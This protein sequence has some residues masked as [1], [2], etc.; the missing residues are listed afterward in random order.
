MGNHVPTLSD[1]PSGVPDTDFA[2]AVDDALTLAVPKTSVPLYAQTIGWEFVPSGES[3]VDLGGF[4]VNAAFGFGSLWAAVTNPPQVVRIDPTTGTIIATISAGS[5]PANLLNGICCSDDAVWFTDFTAGRVGR[6]D[7]LTNTASFPAALSGFSTPLRGIVFDGT[8]IW[9]VISLALSDGP[10]QVKK[11]DPSTNTVVATVTVGNEVYYPC[12]DGADHLWVPNFSDNTVSR[13][14]IT[15]HTVTST[16]VTLANPQWAFCNGPHVFVGEYGNDSV[17][18]YSVGSVSNSAR[19]SVAAGAFVH[20]ILVVDD[21]LWVVE[22]G[23]NQIQV[24]NIHSGAVMKTIPVGVDPA[25]IVFDGRD[26]WNVDAIGETLR[27][28]P[29]RSVWSGGQLGS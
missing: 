12:W 8:Y 5:N 19:W 26:I 3:V 11:I 2:Q 27:R 15:N 29:M 17:A 10:S 13:V 9:F 1:Y 16:I 21:Q 20:G 25:G 6:I 22:S 23:L 18:R 24:L 4:T 14:H 28:H 7:P